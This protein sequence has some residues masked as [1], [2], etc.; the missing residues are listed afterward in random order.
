MCL[1]SSVSGSYLRLLALLEESLLAGLL[2]GLLGGEVLWLRDLVNLLLVEAGDVD[3]V[4]GGDNVAS[5]DAAQGNAVDLERSGDEENTLVEGLEEDNAL[6]A[7]T[8][9]EEDQDGTGLEGLAGSPGT[10]RLA[11]LYFR[12]FVSFDILVPCT[13]LHPAVRLQCV[14]T[15]QSP[16]QSVCVL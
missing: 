1:L 13:V 16:Y 15:S 8:A 6:A 7:E 4:G 9:G 10:D 14:P 11:N 2:L 3:L 12:N 5:V